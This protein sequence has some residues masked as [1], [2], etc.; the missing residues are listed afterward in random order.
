[1]AVLVLAVAGVVIGVRASQQVSSQ[2]PPTAT[3]G[4]HPPA[5]D[6]TF[7]TAAGK[8]VSVSSLRG[9]PTLLW[10]VA[11]W[12]SSCQAGTQAVAANIGRLRAA[13]VRVVELE[14]YRDLGQ[15]GPDITTFGKAFAGASYGDPD[16]TWGTASA[17]LSYA[18]DP[19]GYL[20][21]YYLLDAQGRIAYVNGSPGS[22]MSDLLAHTGK[23]G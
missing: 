20:D 22:T 7:T 9:H 23:L 3:A 16:W 12:C 15:P 14:L 6:G 8:Q 10:F 5:P 18:Y 11:T 13:G 4:S 1:V 17:P 2:R 19:Q 21:I